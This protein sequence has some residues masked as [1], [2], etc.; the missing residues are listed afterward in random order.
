[1]VL[2]RC[3]TLSNT[4]LE[5]RI[6]LYRQ[7]GICVAR[8]QQEAELK[9]LRAAMPEYGAL[10]S[11]G[12]QDVL[13]RL[14]KPYHAFFRRLANGAKPGFPRFHGTDRSHAFTATEDGNGARLEKGSLVLSTSG[15]IAGHWSR[16]LAGTPKTVTVAREA[17]GW[18]GS[19]SCA[20]VPV[21]PLPQ[22]GR[23]TGIDGGLKVFL[24]TADGDA[25][26]TPRHYRRA[27]R[28][29]V[30][31]ARRVS[32][33][34]K[35]RHRRRKAVCVLAT[36]HQQVRRQRADFHHKTALALVRAYDTLSVEAIQP[37]NLS[38]RP[39]PKPDGTG[40]GYEPNGA[41]RKAGLNT[42]IQDA[43]WR[44]VLS[45]LAF[46]AAGAGKRVAAVN[47]A[48]TTQECSGSAAG[49]Q[50]LWGAHL[51]ESEGAHACL[52]HLRPDPGP[53]RA[54]GQDHVRARAA[55]AGT[56]GVGCGNEPRTRR[57]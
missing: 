30:Q 3:R 15:R 57:A 48:D 8:F 43:G 52:P 33:R 5:Q 38:R 56:R 37:A 29:L 19:F 14:D 34:V 9:H 40:G 11:Q 13:A 42:S 44:H 36:A 26:E 10:H 16:P 35:G 2:W 50:R 12:L 23:E 22:T 6:T 4:A 55:P 20:D 54:R 17:D 27:E 21:Q 31:C 18:D 45:I 28:A 24:L 25:V 49:V 46:T 53:R 41:S 47:P 1:V 7:R 51:H 39:E 32:K